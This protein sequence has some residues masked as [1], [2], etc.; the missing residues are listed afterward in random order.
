MILKR[1]VLYIFDNNFKT[2]LMKKLLLSMLFAGVTGAFALA[3]SCTPGANFVDSVYGVWPDTIQNLPSAA[4][5]TAYST[6]LNFKV[7]ATVTAGLDP[8]GQFVGSPIQSFTVTGVQGLPAGYNFACN[9]GNCTY[10]GGAN[11]C[12]NIYGTTATAGTYP[13]TINVDATVLVTII[14]GLP[15]TPVTQ[16]VSFSGYKIIVGNAGIITGVVSPLSLY[17]NP[18]TG[19]LNVTGISS[20]M[21]AEN[22]TI[23]NVNGQ[24]LSAI[25][26]KGKNAITMNLDFL[27]EGIYFANLSTVDG[28]KSVRFVKQ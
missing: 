14:P 5:N 25:N 19:T 20:E 24:V 1:S 13:A 3:Q 22:I 10:A 15:P 27:K 18:T 4:T 2:N 23:T 9:I 11:G 6:D 21:N 16:S 12:A 8:S 26:V 7:P 17:P 28:V